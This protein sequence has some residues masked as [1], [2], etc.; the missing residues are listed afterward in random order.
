MEKLDKSAKKAMLRAWR[1]REQEKARG[2]YP[3]ADSRLAQFFSELEAR[4]ARHGCFHDIR[5]SLQVAESMSLSEPE[6]DAL[7]DWCN[8]H[9]GFCDCEIAANTF[10]H[11]HETR[12][13]A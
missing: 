3:L 7:L 11:W 13:P 1:T 8:Q 6:L 12:S 4:R 9:G 10:Q 2:L 5:H